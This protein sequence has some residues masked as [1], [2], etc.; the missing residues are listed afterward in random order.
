MSGSSSTQGF[1]GS[2]ERIVIREALSEDL[3]GI[4]RVYDPYAISTAATFDTAPMTD[5]DRRDWLAQRPGGRDTVLVAISR[6]EVVGFAA[7]GPFRPRVA[8]ETS[9]ETSVY[10][11]ADSIGR[12]IGSALYEALFRSLSNQEVHRAYAAISLPNPAS[13]ALHERF[14]FQHVGTLSE[15]GRK[16]ARY[17]DVAWFERRMS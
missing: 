3:L 15:V 13:V 6:G 9:V 10:V 16:F 5:A 1:E 7:S 17:W 8:Y 11:V 4:A 2:R 12:G 14:G